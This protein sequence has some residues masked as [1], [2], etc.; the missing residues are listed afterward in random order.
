MHDLHYNICIIII[1]ISAQV[2][3]ALH[4]MC[5]RII[6]TYIH[7]TMQRSDFVKIL[8]TEMFELH[9]GA[10]LTLSVATVMKTAVAVCG[11]DNTL[12]A[13]T[14]ATAH[15]AAAVQSTAVRFALASSRAQRPS[16]VADVQWKEQR[17]VPQ[18]PHSALHHT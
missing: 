16:T 10:F 14:T 17:P 4:N 1:L 15:A 7:A 9:D 12:R 8:F 18:P 5:Q 3:N 13:V 11:R 6:S 2:Y